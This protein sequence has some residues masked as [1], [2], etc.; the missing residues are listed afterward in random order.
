LL[1]QET[2]ISPEIRQKALYQAASLLEKMGHDEAAGTLFRQFISEFPDTPAARKFRIKLGL[3]EPETMPA[4]Q[5]EPALEPSNGPEP[6]APPLK[7]PD[8][9][10]ATD[11]GPTCPACNGGMVRRRA[12]GGPHAGRLF[13]VCAA[14]PGCRRVMPAKG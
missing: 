4:S 10:P 1:L 8:A 2:G 6:V 7:A 5:A 13:W 9:V 3:P 14:W 11:S 12:N